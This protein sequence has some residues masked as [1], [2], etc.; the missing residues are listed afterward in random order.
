MFACSGTTVI[1]CTSS[2]TPPVLVR[3]AGGLQIVVVGDEEPVGARRPDRVLDRSL[4]ER[5]RAAS[6]DVVTEHRADLVQPPDADDQPVDALA[7]GVAAL[8]VEHDERGTGRQPAE[9]QLPDRLLPRP[10]EDPRAAERGLVVRRERLR[11]AGVDVLLVL[12]EHPPERGGQC[13]V[14]GHPDASRQQ[15]GVRLPRG[16]HRRVGVNTLLPPLARR[17]ER[18]RL[19]SAGRLLVESEVRDVPSRQALLEGVVP[20]L[21]N[22]VQVQAERVAPGRTADG[23][24]PARVVPGNPNIEVG[25]HPRSSLASLRRQYE[26]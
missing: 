3:V 12:L 24:V 11:A 13:G 18:T 17:H 16:L 4:P 25:Q 2:P 23:A 10:A 5:I 22:G 7:E 14:G 6:L 26:N 20:G 9:E 19:A 21:M 8:G 15:V 1:S